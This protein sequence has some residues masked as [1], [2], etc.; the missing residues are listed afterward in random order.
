MN[1]LT[2]LD[3]FNFKSTAPTEYNKPE[4]YMI[5]GSMLSDHHLKEKY[6]NQLYKTCMVC[7]L[8]DRGNQCLEQD[9]FLRDPHILSNQNINNV[10][11]V[12]DHPEW[13]DLVHR[14]NDT[15]TT[16]ISLLKQNNIY[17]QVYITY[18]LKCAGGPANQIHYSSCQ[19]Y[20]DLE[21]KSLKPKL[22]IT[23]GE[24]VFKYL[25]KEDVEYK[26]SLKTIIKSRY[27]YK[28]LPICDAASLD[29]NDSIR[30]IGKL[31]GAINEK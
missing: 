23:V 29:F 19:S 26:N 11:L 8:C 15:E 30:T 12:L 4:Q 5:A 13:S 27:N 16:L 31:V 2:Q 14:D 21:I 7:S 28:M 22:I 20:I 18:L 17:D 6:I 25:S 24:R 1:Q 10:I 9:G 3:W